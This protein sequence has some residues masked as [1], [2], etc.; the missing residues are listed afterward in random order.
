MNLLLSTFLSCDRLI[1]IVTVRLN[2]TMMDNV[3]TALPSVMDK[4]LVKEVTKAI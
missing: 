1:V 3:A 4:M 2:V